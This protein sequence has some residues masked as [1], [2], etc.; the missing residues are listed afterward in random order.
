[1]EKVLHNEEAL[2][3]YNL[4]KEKGLILL[5]AVVGSQAYGTSLP[6]S[7][8]DIKFVY[9]EEEEKVLT[10]NQVSQINVNA[11]FVGYEIG[12]FFELLQT[13]N[14]N[15]LDLTK[16]PSECIKYKHPLYEEIVEKNYKKFLSKKCADSFGKY[17]SSQIQKA[18]GTNKKIVNPLEKERKTILDFCWVNKD[19]GVISLKD[20]LHSIAITTNICGVTSLPHMKNC[21][22]LFVDEDVYLKNEAKARQL[23]FGN[24]GVMKQFLSIKRDYSSWSKEDKEVYL[25]VL[26]ELIIK[27][28][29]FKKYKGIEDKDGVQLV[30]SSI[31]KNKEPVTLFYCNYEGFSKY[32]KDYKEYWEWVKN[33]NQERYN[34]NIANGAEYDSKNMSHCHRLLDMCI[35]ILRDGELNI[36]RSNRKQLLDI[37]FGKYPYESLLKDAEEKKELIEQLVVTTDLPDSVDLE[38]LNSIHLNLRNKFYNKK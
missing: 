7:D 28:S 4:L 27:D 31:E 38:W 12:R 37:R 14:P 34:Q 9:I 21:F 35:E 1:M 17:A 6:T 16:S 8:E 19:Q 15:I 11:D 2:L 26:E 24:W 36:K 20:F 3:K 18:R 29:S 32:C 30:L 25:T 5:E 22:L 23:T 10:G 13:G 33:R